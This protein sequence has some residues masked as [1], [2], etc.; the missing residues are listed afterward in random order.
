[1][2]PPIGMVLPRPPFI[3]VN[4][5][6]SPPPSRLGSSGGP[7]A[8]KRAK[9]SSGRYG[10]ALSPTKSRKRRETLGSDAVRTSSQDLP[11]LG[12]GSV[13]RGSGL[14][15]S[16]G[17]RIKGPQSSGVG[18]NRLA[19][20][21]SGGDKISVV[22]KSG[23]GE[24]STSRAAPAAP[25]PPPMVDFGSGN[26]TASAAAESAPLP[27]PFMNLGGGK[28]EAAAELLGSR[29]QGAAL[30][31]LP[32]NS[33][34]GHNVSKRVEPGIDGGMYLPLQSLEPSCG[35]ETSTPPPWE[36]SGSACVGDASQPPLP[37]GSGSAQIEAA[38]GGSN[39]Q[40]P[41][42]V[43]ARD[44][45]PS[46]PPG[47]GG[48]LSIA[49]LDLPKEQVVLGSS[50]VQDPENGLSVVWA[51]EGYVEGSASDQGTCWPGVPAQQ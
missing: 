37:T 46:L 48:G 33:G 42:D 40:E 41:P 35:R 26:H 32:L 6:T 16:G 21:R 45:M 9:Y 20:P 10:A 11:A 27:P 28:S 5:G 8:A 38:P 39:I 31:P 22:P 25:L 29:E 7:S 4:E 51:M 18:E 50:A 24:A 36:A 12:A 49:A 19:Q 17:V 43:T 44:V 47:F 23:E 13:Q 34:S 15:K 1:M 30:P 14:P 3:R 2:G